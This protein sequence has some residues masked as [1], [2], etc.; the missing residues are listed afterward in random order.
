MQECLYIPSCNDG[1]RNG[2]ETGVD[3]GGSCSACPVI[4]TPSAIS[5]EKFN[6]WLLFALLTSL[7]LVSGVL[8]L[9]H[10]EFM[11]LLSRLDMLLSKHAEKEVLLTREER[12]L[13]LEKITKAEKKAEV[14]DSYANL[15]EQG[16]LLLATIAKLPEAFEKEEL[17]LALKNRK[18]TPL[19]SNFYETIYSL[20][21]SKTAF[22]LTYA[23]AISEEM[24]LIVT[25]L[26]EGKP[27]ELERSL[28]QFVIDE[29][30]S[31]LEEAF[32]RIISIFR[33]LQFEQYEFAK[34]EYDKLLETYEDLPEEDQEV[35]YDE[36]RHVFE[37]F[38]YAFE[39][40]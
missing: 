37:T 2:D 1:I 8:R 9:Y 14:N 27:A 26:S 39:R 4:E 22:N 18:V 32:I 13:L 21:E 31:Y 17:E 28:K 35:M 5:P 6:M 24:R 11:K 20:E 3:C 15:A 29:N 7:L 34:A 36:T 16:R 38:K 12:N 40:A 23:Y 33:A 30:Q 25:E 10:E 19:L